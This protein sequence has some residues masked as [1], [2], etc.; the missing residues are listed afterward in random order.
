MPLG[1]YD[2]KGQYNSS[3]ILNGILFDKIIHK[4]LNWLPNEVTWQKVVG[5]TSDPIDLKTLDD[6]NDTGLAA[7]SIYNYTNGPQDDVDSIEVGE[8]INIIFKELDINNMDIIYEFAFYENNVY[9]RDPAASVN[10]WLSCNTI[11]AFG[12]EKVLVSTDST[13]PSGSKNTIWIAP[14]G[15][16][17]IYI[18]GKLYDPL[19]TDMMDKTIYDT[20][21]KNKD[22]FDYF[23]NQMNEILE[24]YNEFLKHKSNLLTLIHITA[25][26]REYYEDLIT[27]SDITSALGSTYFNNYIDEIQEFI[28]HQLDLYYNN[29]LYGNSIASWVDIGGKI[30][31]N[32][33]EVSDIRY[34]KNILGVLT[35]SS[36]LFLYR[37]NEGTFGLITSIELGDDLIAFDY[38]VDYSSHIHLYKVNTNIGK[39]S[40][41]S[42]NG[43]INNSNNTDT[44]T[45]NI[46]DI[47]T[48]YIDGYLFLYGL[49]ENDN[50]YLSY[51]FYS[52]KLTSIIKPSVDNEVEE[53][54]F[55]IKNIQPVE[56]DDIKINYQIFAKRGSHRYYNFT[57][58]SDILS[59][60]DSTF[61]KYD[62]H[63]MSTD[64]D[65]PLSFNYLPIFTDSE[66]ED[67]FITSFINNIEK[68]D[69]A[70]A[71]GGWHHDIYSVNMGFWTARRRLTLEEIGV[72]QINRICPGEFEYIILGTD[73]DGKTKIVMSD[74]TYYKL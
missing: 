55:I 54:E 13:A 5:T 58:L 2:T 46:K 32:I 70:S 74:M 49:D 22:P 42:S 19:I 67:K 43:D 18:D 25:E 45:F 6:I 29:E 40:I 28:E 20:N 1:D 30:R 66:Y 34:K 44:F 53:I 9:Y 50:Y 59:L 48:S 68:T 51:T 64:R 35:R 39:Y 65:F 15:K 23:H 69:S 41:I 63:S 52:R 36:E 16:L 11:N 21:N 8:P 38:D 31:Q 7:Y 37:Y 3:S 26:E 56:E 17:Y 61:E 72:K 47:Y 4:I 57:A 10:K 73:S 12:N 62:A 71:L 14:N 27:K 33:D 60:T 24:E